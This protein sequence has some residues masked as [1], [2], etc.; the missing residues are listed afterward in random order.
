LGVVGPHP[1]RLTGILSVAA[2]H[3]QIG[4]ENLHGLDVLV[5]RSSTAR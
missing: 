1:E 2:R 4:D 3:D 5:H